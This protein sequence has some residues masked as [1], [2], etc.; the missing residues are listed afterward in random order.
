MVNACVTIFDYFHECVFVN[1]LRFAFFL[2]SQIEFAGVF[3]K[4]Y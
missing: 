1:S 2:K 4:I 3:C